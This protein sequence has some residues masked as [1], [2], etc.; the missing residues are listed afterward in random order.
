MTLPLPLVLLWLFSGWRPGCCLGCRLGLRL[1]LALCLGLPV[2]LAS[3]GGLVPPVPFGLFEEGGVLA[4]LEWWSEGGPVGGDLRLDFSCLR[5]SSCLACRVAMSSCRVALSMFSWFCLAASLASRRLS[6]ASASVLGVLGYARESS[7]NACFVAW[8]ASL[9]AFFSIAILVASSACSV[10][11]L[12]TLRLCGIQVM[13]PR[14]WVMRAWVCWTACWSKLLRVFWFSG[15]DWGYR[16]SK[17]SRSSGQ[18]M[19]R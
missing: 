12:A 6:T 14:Y 7:S 2:A 9:E 17:S 19:S 3:G 16:C 13:V 1:D 8:E 18:L 4:F 15:L 11:V 5:S 10:I